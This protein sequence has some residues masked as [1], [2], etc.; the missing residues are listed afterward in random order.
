MVPSGYYSRFSN[1]KILHVGNIANNAY[2]AA[3][4]DRKHG[5]NSFAISPNYN[6]VMGFPFWEEVSLHVTREEEFNARLLERNHPSPSWFA[7]GTWDEIIENLEV[8]FDLD[9]E[10]SEKLTFMSMAASYSRRQMQAIIDYSRLYIKTVVET[11][12]KLEKKVFR[13]IVLCAKLVIP[14]AA[15]LFLKTRIAKRLSSQ[16]VL[17]ISSHLRIWLANTALP[18]FNRIINPEEKIRNFISKFDVVVYYGPWNAIVSMYNLKPSYISLEHGTLRDFVWTDYAWA[19]ESREGY[20]NS[21]LILITNSDCYDKAIELRGD[22]TKVI[23]TSHPKSDYDFVG[24]RD[25]RKKNINEG[26]LR[27]VILVPSRHAYPKNIDIG[28]GN[29]D[30]LNCVVQCK[31]KNLD[32]KFLFVEWGDEVQKTKNLIKDLGIESYIEWIPL[33]SRAALKRLKV[34]ILAVIDQVKIPAYGGITEDC[35]GLGV[36]VITAHSGELDNIYYGSEAPVLGAN[37]AAELVKQISRLT[38][39][40]SKIMLNEIFI[41][42]TQW[43]DQVLSSEIVAKQRFDTYARYLEFEYDTKESVKESK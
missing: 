21:N 8:N 11:M 24:L 42:S 20:R 27:N 3:R 10:K 2:N 6:H 14:H 41:K 31:S 38:E 13:L 5:L 1:I 18:V 28:K 25:L 19:K 7:T 23:K 37:T 35:L 40:A 26:K 43:Y 29:L 34:E 12:E 16:K 17:P 4:N 15:Y 39:P 36:P 9:M 30:I 33:H 22:K 32:L